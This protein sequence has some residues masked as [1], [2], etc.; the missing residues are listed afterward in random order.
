MIAPSSPQL[1]RNFPSGLTL[2]DRIAPQCA[3]CLFTHSPLSTSHHQSRPSLSPLTR[4]FPFGPQASAETILECLARV[5]TRSA[6]ST[7]HMN[8]SPLPPLARNLP[9]GLH[10]TLWTHP[11]WPD[12]L[13]RNVPS[14]LSHRYTQSLSPPAAKSRPLGLQASTK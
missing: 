12:S 8:T 3:S 1:A 14:A 9:S 7:S 2:R 5:C 4:A 13:A 10:P 11:W 6:V